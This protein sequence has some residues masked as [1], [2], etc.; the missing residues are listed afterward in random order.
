MKLYNFSQIR[1]YG[2]G[3]LYSERR[4][5]G[6]SAEEMF[7]V[8][9]QVERYSEFVPWCTSSKVTSTSLCGLRADLVIGFPP[10]IKESY[11]S[12]VTMFEP[13][14]VTAVSNDLK[15]F[16]FLKTVWK[17]DSQLGVPGVARSCALDFAVHFKFRSPIYA[18]FSSLFFDEVVKRNVNAF[19]D[20]AN[21]RFGPESI[22]RRKPQVM[23]CK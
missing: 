22:P 7:T 9:S 1:H 8:V 21:K 13:N 14:L 19:L 23:M 11:T 6:Y 10:L 15:L 4:V 17:F 16:T 3:S 20:E 12:D 5:L 18:Q 2:R